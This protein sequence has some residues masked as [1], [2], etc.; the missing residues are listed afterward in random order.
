MIK[1]LVL[2]SIAIV[3]IAAAPETKSSNYYDTPIQSATTT[4]TIF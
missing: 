4:P 2:L 1:I 3:L